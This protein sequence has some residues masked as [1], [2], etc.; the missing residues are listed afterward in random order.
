MANSPALTLLTPKTLP[1]SSA[2]GE[3][4]DNDGGEEGSV[5]GDGGGDLLLRRCFLG[6]RKGGH[7]TRG[8][9]GGDGGGRLGG[10]YGLSGVDREGDASRGG[11]CGAGGAAAGHC[12][13]GGGGGGSPSLSWWSLP[14]SEGK[15]PVNMSVLSSTHKVVSKSELS[16]WSTASAMAFKAPLCWEASASEEGKGIMSTPLSGPAI[17]GCK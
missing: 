2:W 3:V 16:A 14:R 5:E 4:N 13:C 1:C 15:S 17:A 8:V 6:V 12:G 9:M 11:G 10:G 7:R